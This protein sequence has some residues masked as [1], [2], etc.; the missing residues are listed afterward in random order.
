MRRFLLTKG[1]LGG[2]VAVPCYAL[3]LWCAIAQ[4]DAGFYFWIAAAVALAAIAE[5]VAD[6][7][8]HWLGLERVER[9]FTPVRTPSPPGRRPIWDQ[10]GK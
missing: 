9:F 2:S 1:V 4:S 7:V 8:A 3:G 5:W 10:D 6:H